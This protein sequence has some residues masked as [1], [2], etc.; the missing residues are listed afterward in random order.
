MEKDSLFTPKTAIFVSMNEFSR[1]TSNQGAKE[2]F[3]YE[4]H[5]CI[6]DSNTGTTLGKRSLK[7]FATKQNWPLLL[8]TAPIES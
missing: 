1:Q 5:F 6:F 7:C 3:T 4:L 8:N 2:M